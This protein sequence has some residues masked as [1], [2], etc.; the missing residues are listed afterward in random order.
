M[1]T[2]SRFP[3]DTGGDVRPVQHL[4]RDPAFLQGV[5]DQF[6]AQAGH[7]RF[8]IRA[9]IEHMQDAEGEGGASS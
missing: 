4:L 3:S 5:L 7:G 1:K 9:D 6:V 2:R 8:H